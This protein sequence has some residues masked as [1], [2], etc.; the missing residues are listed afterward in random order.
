[1]G[2]EQNRASWGPSNRWTK[3]KA[4]SFVF[5][6]YPRHLLFGTHSPARCPAARCPQAFPT[7]PSE[8]LGAQALHQ[9]SPLSSRRF[10]CV[11]LRLQLASSSEGHLGAGPTALRLQ[12]LFCSWYF[13]IIYEARGATTQQKRTLHRIKCYQHLR[14]FKAYTRV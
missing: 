6:P 8:N 13:L 9:A 14:S 2:S 12:Q 1:M 5:S 11:I 4:S 10:L 7:I 3:S